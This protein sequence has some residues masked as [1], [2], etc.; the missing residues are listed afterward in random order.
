MRG[1]PVRKVLLLTVVALVI[2]VIAIPLT[3]A[4]A[5]D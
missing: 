3:V 4:F 2:S 1:G 5:I